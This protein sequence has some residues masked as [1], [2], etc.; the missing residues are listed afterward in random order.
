MTLG[1]FGSVLLLGNARNFALRSDSVVAAMPTSSIN[2]LSE[3]VG[4]CNRGRN[5]RIIP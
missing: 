4:F 1:C 2:S 3:T 5:L